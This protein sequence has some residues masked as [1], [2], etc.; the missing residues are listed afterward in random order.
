[1]DYF[2]KFEFP[3]LGPPFTWTLPVIEVALYQINADDIVACL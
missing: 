1:V 3:T 2:H